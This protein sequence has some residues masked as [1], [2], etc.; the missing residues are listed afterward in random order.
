MPDPV[1]GII[2]GTIGQGA[3]N[4]IGGMF[5][6]NAQRGAADQ[7]IGAQMEMRRQAMEYLSKMFGISKEALQPFINMGT[8]ASNRLTSQLGDLTAPIMMDQET[9]ENTPGYQFLKKQGLDAV[10]NQSVLHGLSGAQLKG[11]A[12]F[13]KGLA[14]STYKTQFDIANINKTNA[15]NRLFQT[16]EAGRGAAGTLG[17]LAMSGANSLL[18]N[19]AAMG[20]TI[21]DYMIGKGNA[22]AGGWMNM[23]TNIGNVAGAMP[24][25]PYIGN[26]MYPGGW[27]GGMPAS[28]MYAGYKDGW[29]NGAEI[30]G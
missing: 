19:T 13:V 30:G 27:G 3:F 9:L 1:S 11:S 5:G 24:Y 23:F 7:A 4:A 16:A 17:G 12:D 6:S 20:K 2:G 10:N 28:G 15:F 29:G 26:K 18:G 22:E 14:D 8:D 25:M 21:G